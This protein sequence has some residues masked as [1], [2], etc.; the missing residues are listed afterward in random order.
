MNSVA[1]EFVAGSPFRTIS[2]IRVF[3]IDAVLESVAV[4]IS[5][6]HAYI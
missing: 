2:K 5:K 4:L 3:F 1:N 6:K